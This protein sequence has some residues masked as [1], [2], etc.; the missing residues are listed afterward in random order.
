MDRKEKLNMLQVLDEETLT[1]RFLI[2]LYSEGMGCKNIQYTH[3]VMESGR[4]IIYSIEDE[5]GDPVY[6]GVQVKRT[7][8]TTRSVDNVFRQI[9]EAF[10]ESF[11]DLSDGKKKDLD[12]IVLITSNNFTEGA[13]KS[14]WNSLKTVNLHR[15]VT[16]V[17]GNH[18]VDLLDEY[19]PSAFWEEYDYFSRYFNAMKREF[20]TIKDVSAIGQREPIS[21]ENIYV[22]LQLSEK[23][24]HEAPYDR[25][26]VGIE[27]MIREKER[28]RKRVFNANE[29]IKLNKAHIK[30]TS[31]KK[32]CL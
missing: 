15:V 1:K 20:E 22:T 23:P 12:R 31:I 13:K 16:C 30:A 11:T 14:L 6:T 26:I 29:A 5:Y 3:G 7:K 2:L 4:D 19:L 24:E 10:G 8:I 28:K 32:A 21:L 27:W 18:L 9:T 17:D 25:K